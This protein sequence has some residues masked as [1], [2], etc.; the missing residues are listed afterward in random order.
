VPKE[1]H[2]AFSEVAYNKLQ[3]PAVWERAN[4]NY[5]RVCCLEKRDLNSGVC[6]QLF[7]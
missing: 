4:R 5:S 3:I 7:S 6:S 2:I 1:T